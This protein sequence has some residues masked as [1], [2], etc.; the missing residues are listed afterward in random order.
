MV[1]T[2]IGNLS[3]I[4]ERAIESLLSADAILCEDTRV[5]AK[6]LMARNISTPTRTLHDHNEQ[7]RI[8]FLIQQLENGSRFALVS[9]AGTPLVSDPGYRLVRAAIAAGIEITSIPGPNAVVTALTLSG[10]PPLPFMFLGFPP[11]MEAR[12]RAFEALRAGEQA[13]IRSTLIWYE[14]P[15]RLV[16]TLKDLI[17]VFG[18]AREAAVGRELTKRFEEMVRGTLAEVLSHFE[19]TAPRGEITLLI[20][21]PAEDDSGADDL[22]RHL[23]EALETHSVKD[24]AA[25]VA[26][27][28]KLPKRTVYARA[29]EL[30]RKR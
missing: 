1:A 27:F 15:H 6:L 24:A 22:D 29:L 17:E 19:Q 4:S 13:G 2:P 28:I 18:P 9:D 5:T 20:G 10:L 11:K 21:P 25:L 30:S 8:P 12:V 14:A 7:E 3:D 16:D 26:G 23:E